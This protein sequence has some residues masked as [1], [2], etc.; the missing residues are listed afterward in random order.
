MPLWKFFFSPL[1]RACSP[2]VLSI[3]MNGIDDLTGQVFS[4][5]RFFNYALKGST[6]YRDSFP[7][8]RIKG[9]RSQPTSLLLRLQSGEVEES[10]KTLQPCPLLFRFL[11]FLFLCYTNRHIK[12]S[13]LCRRGN[14]V[15]TDLCFPMSA[16]M[17]EEVDIAHSRR[18]PESRRLK[19]HCCRVSCAG[20]Q[21]RVGH[22]YILP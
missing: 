11:Y 1:E 10:I 14:R 4:K 5:D 13:S 8:A 22:S 3:E 21:I 9:F 19:S 16:P 7:Y 17:S 18:L 2:T 20:A 15:L 12:A 6:P